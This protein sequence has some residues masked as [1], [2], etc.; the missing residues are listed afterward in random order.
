M[1]FIPTFRSTNNGS[2]TRAPSVQTFKNQIRNEDIH[3]A[4][5]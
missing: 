1:T 5:I 3:N 4:H 2:S